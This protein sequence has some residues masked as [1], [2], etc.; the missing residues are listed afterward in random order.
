MARIIKR[1]VKR[2]PRGMET[3]EVWVE[4]YLPFSPEALLAFDQL[5]A[6]HAG[7]AD[8]AIEADPELAELALAPIDSYMEAMLAHDVVTLA[9]RFLVESRKID[10]MHDQR[11]RASVRIVQS[12]VNDE[13]IASPLYF[14]GAWVAKLVVDPGSLEW[15]MIEDRI[16]DAVSFSA[17]VT[18]IRIRVADLSEP[19]EA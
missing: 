2:D 10:V 5:V 7:D 6:A 14:P 12:F 15:S 9:E 19:P 16:I 8:A 11:E 13:Q 18:L 1:T 4:C 17:W 3:G